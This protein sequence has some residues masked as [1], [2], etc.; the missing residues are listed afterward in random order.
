MEQQYIFIGGFL[1]FMII[2]GIILWRF[3][4]YEEWCNFWRKPYFLCHIT[5]NSRVIHT[6]LE[7][8]SSSIQWYLTYKKSAYIIPDKRITHGFGDVFYSDVKNSV[9]IKL[10]S[11][12]ELKLIEE[13]RKTELFKSNKSNITNKEKALN[14]LRKIPVVERFVIKKVN[15]IDMII[16]AN[17]FIS[18]PYIIIDACMLYDFLTSHFGKDIMANPKDLMDVLQE[19]MGIIIFAICFII[20]L[21]YA[22]NIISVYRTRSV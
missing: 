21:F 17:K 8:K 10:E 14:L 18:N 5:E 1:G 22:P 15:T 2:S 9:S 11:L 7:L 3:G 6:V 20:L 19:H 13:I 12:E 16:L 4:L